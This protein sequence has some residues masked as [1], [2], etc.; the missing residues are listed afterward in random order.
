MTEQNIVSIFRN[1][2][3]YETII[4]IMQDCSDDLVDPEKMQKAAEYA[5]LKRK[6]ALNDHWLS[7]LPDDER[8]LVEKHLV[9]GLSW[10]RISSQMASQLG[11]DIPCDERTLQ[12]LQ[13]KAIKRIYDFMKDS[14]HDELDF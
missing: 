10:P 13:A 8:M 3:R 11:A 7:Y 12:R 5:V 6:L 2:R 14:F 4:A 1:R 9:E